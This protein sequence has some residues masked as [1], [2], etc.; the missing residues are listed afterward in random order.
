M[1]DADGQILEIKREWR[2]QWLTA[3]N[4]WV[5]HETADGRFQVEHHSSDGPGSSNG[6]SPP[7]SYNT[8]RQAAARLLQL[9][10]CGP[11][12]PQSWPEAICIGSTTTER[13]GE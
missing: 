7:T 6:V 11:V 12:A 1:S 2:Q 5:I 9:L 13:R 4:L 3:T 10:A 8:K